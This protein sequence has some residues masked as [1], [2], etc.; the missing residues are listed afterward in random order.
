M[1]RFWNVA[2]PLVAA[3]MLA[4]LAALNRPTSA[5]S[6]PS[7]ALIQSFNLQAT[8]T[9]LTPLEL[10]AMLIDTGWAQGSGG[11]IGP[12]INIKKCL[13]IYYPNVASPEIG[14][15]VAHSL[16]IAPNPFTESR[17]VWVAL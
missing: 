14:P 16:R 8:G 9:L 10:R 12:A 3:A 17:R 7:C 13:R 4:G 2:V 6:A 1:R 11:H 5:L 15:A